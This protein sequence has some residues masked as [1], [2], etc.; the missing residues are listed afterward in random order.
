[1]KNSS[2]HEN[3]KRFLLLSGLCSVVEFRDAIQNGY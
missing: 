1:M 2:M 3:R